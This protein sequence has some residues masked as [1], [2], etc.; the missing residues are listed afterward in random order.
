MEDVVK[1]RLDKHQQEL[2]DYDKLEFI[3]H[4]IASTERSPKQDVHHN[5]IML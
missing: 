3:P 5:S 4:N 2:F 1:L